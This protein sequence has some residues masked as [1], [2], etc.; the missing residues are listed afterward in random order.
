MKRAQAKFFPQQA[1]REAVFDV[2]LDV[3]ADRSHHGRL[4]V[5]VCG[6]GAAAQAGAVSGLLGGGGMV[7]E[8]HVLTPGAL[9]RARRPAEDASAR[10]RKNKGA[11]KRGVAV[12]HGLPTGFVAEFH[13]FV[14]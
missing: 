2:L 7:E 9:G 3:A 11:V 8:T 14:I 10:D 1:E 13:D 5:A 12:D 6:L 4:R